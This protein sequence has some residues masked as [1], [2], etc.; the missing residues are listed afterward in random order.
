MISVIVVI[1][2]LI[3]ANG[4]LV[5]MEMA[6]VTSQRTRLKIKSEN[7]NPHA[8]DVLA[9]QDAPSDFLA[10]VQIGITLV[11]T[12]ASAVGGAE[13]V[14]FISPVIAA[15]PGLGPYADSLSLGLVI[16]TITFLTLI[17]GELVPK[18]LALRNAE[19]VA[20]ASIKPLRILSWLTHLPMRILSLTTDAILKSVGKP[21]PQLP[22]TSPE[23]IRLLAE[24]GVD[25]GVLL[26]I[27]KRLISGVFD[28]AD[29][30]VQDVMTPRTSIM[31]FD[32]TISPTEALKIATQI[33]YSRYPVYKEHLDSVVGYVHIKD[34]FRAKNEVDLSRCSREIQFIPSRA[35]LPEAFDTLT[36]DSSHMGIIIDEYGGARGLL[37]LEDM[38]EEIVGEIE[39][40][41]SPNGTQITPRNNGEWVFAGTTPIT[42]VGELLKVDFQPDSVYVTLAGFILASLGNIPEVGEE[43]NEHGYIFTVQEMDCLQITSISVRIR[44]SNN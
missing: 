40:E 41:H 25:D 2:T 31:A 5:A 23:E 21:G 9:I 8:S 32:I 39:D 36:R 27:E 38:L 4:L 44:N 3:L 35:S 28:Y 19:N 12:A 6:I 11:G 29:R 10:T 18:Q 1:I 42:E 20:M 24:Q 37:T 13:I 30:R 26:D 33:G 34:I 22:S 15:L 7:G 43:V 17:F 16:V 14:R